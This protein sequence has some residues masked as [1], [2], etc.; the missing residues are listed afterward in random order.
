MA[1]LRREGL[2]TQGGLYFFPPN[3][4]KKKGPSAVFKIIIIIITI[5]FWPA[6]FCRVVWPEPPLGLALR[7]ARARLFLSGGRGRTGGR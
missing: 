3:T 1:Q 2:L 4:K 6:W 7:V 5:P